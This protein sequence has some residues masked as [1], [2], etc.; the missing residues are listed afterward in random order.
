VQRIASS[1][2]SDSARESEIDPWR[3]P[4]T[5]AKTGAPEA[6][7]LPRATSRCRRRS[8]APTPKPKQKQKEKQKGKK[9]AEASRRSGR[10]GGPAARACAAAPPARLLRAAGTAKLAQQFGLTNPHEIRS[11]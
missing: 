8:A 10:A 11:S 5:E 3:I 4:R 1:P 2:A 9:P 6:E 7:A